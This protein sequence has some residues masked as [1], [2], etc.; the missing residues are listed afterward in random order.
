[1]IGDE[2]FR[3][4]F[5]NWWISVRLLFHWQT[6]DDDENSSRCRSSGRWAKWPHDYAF[7][8]RVN[9]YVENHSIIFLIQINFRCEFKL[10]QSNIDYCYDGCFINAGL[11]NSKERF[12]IFIVINYTNLSRISDSR[13]PISMLFSN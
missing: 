8:D 5:Q 13:K 9:I 2:I 12:E 6:F 10:L 4:A 11:C 1:M 7:Q 3:N